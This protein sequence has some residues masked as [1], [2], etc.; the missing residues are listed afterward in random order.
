MTT[1]PFETRYVESFD[2]FVVS[3][4]GIYYPLTFSYFRSFPI[5]NCVMCG[6]RLYQLFWSFVDSSRMLRL[7]LLGTVLVE[8]L[9]LS[10]QRIS[11]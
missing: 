11:L 3:L 9:P 1:C 2:E 6:S 10:V 8:R 4:I 7:S 5:T